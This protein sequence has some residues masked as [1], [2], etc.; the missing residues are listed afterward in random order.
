MF[1]FNVFNSEKA[2]EEAEAALAA[3]AEAE[4][5]RIAEERDAAMAATTSDAGGDE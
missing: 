5:K 3:E 4:A 2:A 1:D